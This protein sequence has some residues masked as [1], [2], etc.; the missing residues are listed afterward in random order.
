MALVIR[1]KNSYA[2]M[3]YHIPLNDKQKE[4]VRG[5]A[6]NENL[7]YIIADGDEGTACIRAY[8]RMMGAPQTTSAIGYQ[9]CYVGDIA[10]SV[11]LNLIYNP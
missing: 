6:T 4:D 11:L 10:A 5:L 3:H 2:E 7:Q 1:F 9:V 8:Q